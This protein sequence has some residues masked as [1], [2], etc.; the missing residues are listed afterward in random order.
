M[1]LGPSSYLLAGAL[2]LAPIAAQQPAAAPTAPIE[3]LWAERA[4]LA[5][6]DDA[7]DRPRLSLYLA[8]AA[9]ANGTAVVVCPGGGYGA[10]ALGHEGH[11]I[12]LHLNRLGISAFV[13]TYRIAP[14][15][16]HPCPQLD[17]QRAIRLVRARAAMWNVDPARIG[18]MGFSAGG[19]LAS[20]ALV[21]FDAGDASAADPVDRGSSRPDF[22]ILVYP[23]IALD[24]P[25]THQG[26]KRNLLGERVGD[27]ALVTSLSTAQQVR[28][29]TPPCFLVHT[30]DDTVVPPENSI[31]F[32]LALRRNKVPAEL[33]IYEH[34]PHGFGLAPGDPVLST[35]PEHL[36]AWLRG[37]GLLQTPAAR[38]R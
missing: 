27:A 36:T 34:G 14:R 29:T 9:T 13:L 25:H 37:R 23:V 19:H 12:A 8:P 24:Q 11:D 21:H 32:Y 38:D 20:T 10:L 1:K 28:A 16:R 7:P 18:V 6:G 15:Y 4:P 35:W 30:T 5:T 33:H 22:G 17:V 2:L 26:S 31:D 3:Y